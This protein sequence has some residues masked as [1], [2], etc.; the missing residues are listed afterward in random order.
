MRNRILPCSQRLRTQLQSNQ[1]DFILKKRVFALSF[2]VL[3]LLILIV[4]VVV[5][6]FVL[7]NRQ[8]L[9]Q[10]EL[11]P[12]G[13]FFLSMDDG[14]VRYF[15][16]AKCCGTLAASSVLLVLCWTRMQIG[17]AVTAGV[18]LFQLGLLHFLLFG[19]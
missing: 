17:I 6:Y 18:A 14:G 15:I 9:L 8:I 3:W 10:T 16:A 7:I 1:V 4:A 5:G 2:I 11:N 13:R 19:A 12:V